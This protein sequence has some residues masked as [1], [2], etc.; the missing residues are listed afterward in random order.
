MNALTAVIDTTG[1]SLHGPASLAFEPLAGLALIERSLAACVAAGVRH[2]RVIVGATQRARCDEIAARHTRLQLLVEVVVRGEAKGS[3]PQRPWWA[4]EEARRRP[5]LVVPADRYLPPEAL[6]ALLQVPLSE[7]EVVLAVER[8][9]GPAA[10][11][12][13]DGLLLREGRVLDSGLP[14]SQGNALWQ[15][16]WVATSAALDA[17]ARRSAESPRQAFDTAMQDWAGLGQLLAS[18]SPGAA[19]GL[20]TC[21]ATFDELEER[22]IRDANADGAEDP[23]ARLAALVYRRAWSIAEVPA[24]VVAVL[25]TSLVAAGLALILASGDAAW[26]AMFGAVI[27]FAGAVARRS[28]G[29]IEA[30]GGRD[31]LGGAWFSALRDDLMGTLVLATLAARLYFKDPQHVTLVLSVLMILFIA[32]HRYVVYFEGLRRPAGRTGPSFRWWFVGAALGGSLERY[33]R[34]DLV[35]ALACLGIVLRLE[36]LAFYASVIGAAALFVLSLLHQIQRGDL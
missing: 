32:Y 22:L 36:T 35:I 29:L 18:E 30:L 15:G 17:L 33:L 9:R 31:V 4:E 16:A 5:C 12:K 27:V 2:V 6:S 23:V 8:G 11:Q 28:E 1:D 24:F 20:A 14:R 3:G 21:R 34:W 26:L 19:W 7:G 25:A 13:T 10:L